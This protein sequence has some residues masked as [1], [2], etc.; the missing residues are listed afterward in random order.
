MRPR[1]S[2]ALNVSFGR[3]VL[4]IIVAC[5]AHPPAITDTA[6]GPPDAPPVPGWAGDRG[7]SQGG[8]EPAPRRDRRAYTARRP[9][10]MAIAA[11]DGVWSEIGG[12]PAAVSAPR[13]L[14]HAA[15]HDP[16]RDRLVVFGGS[17][18]SF[19]DDTW[20]LPLDGS[21]AW[22]QLTTEG[23]PPPARRLHS[24]IYDPEH[25][26]MIIFG[27]VDTDFNN[28]VWALSFNDPPTWSRLDPEGPTPAAR[29]GHSAAYDP[30]AHRMIVIGGYDGISLPHQRRNDVWAL[31]LSED[32]RWRDITPASPGPTARSSHE[33][34]YDS[35]RHRMILFGG[36]DPSFLND[37]WAL[38][39]SGRPEW[40]SLT[41]HGLPPA[42]REEHSAIYDPAGDRIVVFGGHDAL[43]NYGDTW[44]LS[45]SGEPAWT[46]LHPGGSPPGP[47]WGH[48]AIHDRARNQMVLHGGWDHNYSGVTRVLDLSGDP[49]WSEPGG[50][51]VPGPDRHT[52]AAAYDSR[53]NRI[54]L[55]GGSDGR[56]Y[57][58]DTWAL[59][60]GDRPSWNRL[61]TA[62]DP[63]PPRRLAEAIYD[64]LRDRLIVF[65]GFDGTLYNDLWELT[66]ADIPTWKQ[67]H[68]HGVS[69]APRAGHAMIYSSRDDRI[70]VFGGYDGVSAP[71]FRRND[72]WSL[73]LS[74]PPQWHELHPGGDLPAARSSHSMVYDPEHDQAFV[75]GGT[76]P[77]FLDDILVLSLKGNG[78]WEELAPAGDR[79]GPREEQSLAYDPRRDRVVLHGGYDSSLLPHGD[80]WELS[81]ERPPVW[82]RLF[83]TGTP[84]GPRWGHAA[85]YD[86]VGDRLVMH[87]GYA[88]NAL[89]DTWSLSPGAEVPRSL[90]ERPRRGTTRSGKN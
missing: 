18:G 25:D 51:G 77:E 15:I 16:L 67:I 62:G 20:V 64:P 29:G 23:A 65:G 35:T 59:R 85:Q 39:L 48:V 37:A 55:F 61:E 7:M 43:Y 87:G 52:Y 79:P 3:F 6:A 11:D 10:T 73:K 66:F 45:L 89:N 34:V 68:P 28:D 74:T 9:D 83:P 50:L 30:V 27:G 90:S 41:V 76:A 84:P 58:N 24:A 63:P 14:T 49:T 8:D 1:H 31:S 82:R 19:R 4:A 75:F 44:A 47:R 56:S 81:P 36:T 86:P 53:R 26:R 57:F 46:D 80:V 70:I 69:L 12:P 78:R 40:S 72:L 33:M 32:L 2:P 88:F 42:A 13:R 54:V 5:L 60:L 71:D 38:N 22:M 21:V 17:D